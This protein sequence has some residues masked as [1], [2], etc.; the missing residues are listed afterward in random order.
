VPDLL[1]ARATAEP[2]RIALMV[3]GRGSM[4]YGEWET[5]SNVIARNLIN[6]GVAVGDRV[7]TFFENV[8][9]L[10]FALAYFGVL[11]AGATAVPLSSR[12]T[13]RELTSVVDRCAA[14]GSLAGSVA[15]VAPVRRG[16]LSFR[17]RA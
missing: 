10:D 3:A 2:D 9:W 8:E 6:R 15:E 16:A 17:G 5:R 4:S 1:R 14:V 11:K 7:V 12:F 13:G